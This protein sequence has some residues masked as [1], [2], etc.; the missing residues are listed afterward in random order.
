MQSCKSFARRLR[1][2]RQVIHI[3]GAQIVDADDLIAACQQLVAQV[4]AD[5]AGGTGYKDS[6]QRHAISEKDRNFMLLN[7]SLALE[8][9]SR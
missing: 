4:G 7:R 8:K 6:F 2:V 9:L 3:P 5:K 1:Q